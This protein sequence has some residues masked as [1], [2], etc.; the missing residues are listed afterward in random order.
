[1]AWDRLS[2]LHRI[3]ELVWDNIEDEPGVYLF[4]RTI[5]GP[6]RYVGRSDTSLRQR[7]ARRPYK[8][9][10]YKHTYDEGDA[11]YWECEYFHR[12]RTTIENVNHPA[13]PWGY[14]DIEC[15]ICGL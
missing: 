9:F 15:H 5:N 6:C 1:M 3:D 13:K 14:S 2:G 11:Y 10:Q 12:Y 8:Y 4:Y 7:I